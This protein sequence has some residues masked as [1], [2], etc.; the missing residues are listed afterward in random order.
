MSCGISTT[1]YRNCDPKYKIEIQLKEAIFF[2]LHF[3]IVSQ[4]LIIGR[5]G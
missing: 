5:H 2:K 3:S 1:L 4:T